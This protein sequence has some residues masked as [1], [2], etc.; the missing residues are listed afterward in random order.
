LETGSAA[1]LSMQQVSS[2]GLQRGRK[3]KALFRTADQAFSDNAICD[4]DL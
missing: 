3:E 4:P 1:A 2:E